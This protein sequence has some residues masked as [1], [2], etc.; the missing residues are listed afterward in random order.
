MR[1][2]AALDVLTRADTAPDLPRL[3]GMARPNGVVIVGE[4]YWAFATTDGDL[5]EGTMPGS[6]ARARRIP[7]LRGLLQLASSLRPLARGAGVAGGRERLVLLAA[8]LV[9]AVLLPLLPPALELP[10][11][12]ACAAVLVAWLMRGRTLRLHGAEH[13]AIAAVEE[14]RL[15]GAWEG[16]A[17]P[18]RFA[19]RCGTNFAVLALPVTVLVDRLWPI[20]AA[21]LLSSVL[22]AVSLARRDDGA[23]EGGAAPV[24]PPA[25]PDPARPRAATA[26][27]A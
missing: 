20:G 17:R 5:H 24:G 8:V 22:V 21:S 11:G 25:R 13:R 6:R 7:L 18:S 3:G 27:D 19:R 12:L 9:P 26:D 23:L 4:R 15:V 1:R 14:R 10:V 2:A 16:A